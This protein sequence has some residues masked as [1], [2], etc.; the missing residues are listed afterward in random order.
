MV[1]HE[2]MDSTGVAGGDDADRSLTTVNGLDELIALF[3]GQHGR[4]CMSAGPE[5]WPRIWAAV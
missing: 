5:D 3:E 2:R 1:R 4:I